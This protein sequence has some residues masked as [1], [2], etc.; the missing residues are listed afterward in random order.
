MKIGGKE[1][2]FQGQKS[3]VRDGMRD[4]QPGA[5]AAAGVTFWASVIAAFS[6]PGSGARNRSVV[7]VDAQKERFWKRGR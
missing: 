7:A 5:D 3:F 2:A 6:C 1:P 4:K